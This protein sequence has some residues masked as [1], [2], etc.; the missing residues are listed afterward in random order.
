MKALSV[1]LLLSA[2]ALAQNS[3]PQIGNGTTGPPSPPNGLLPCGDTSHAL[4]WTGVIFYCQP[5]SVSAGG[6]FVA[7]SSAGNQII[8]GGFDLGND[9]GGFTVL[10]TG[11]TPSTSTLRFSVSNVGRGSIGFSGSSGSSILFD[12][13]GGINF[14]PGISSSNKLTFNNAGAY[15][16]ASSALL[17]G[18]AINCAG[19]PHG[20]CSAAFNQP[21]ALLGNT[22]GL[23]FLHAQD[24]AGSTAIGFPAVSGTVQVTNVVAFSSLPACAAGTEGTLRGV[25]DSNTVTWG[26]NVAGGSSNH[27][28]AYCDGT[29]WTVA[30]K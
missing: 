10:N 22:S 9:G 18:G 7:L 24:I 29:N 12:V 4:G 23:T 17:A 26:A 14:N 2:L 3:G 15:F 13:D 19:A 28:L 1:L 5:I 30:A 16:A 25:N 27:V 8:T 11:A 6:G 20:T 21:I